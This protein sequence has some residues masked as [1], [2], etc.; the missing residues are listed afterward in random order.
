MLKLLM[1]PAPGERLVRF[2]GDQLSFRLGAPDGRPLPE[3]WQARLR[4]NLGRGQ[5]LRQEIIRAHGRKPHLAQASWR[6]P[7]MRP[8]AAGAWTLSLPLTEAGFFKSKAY[9]IDPSGR[10]Q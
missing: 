3:G 7:P 6:D 4:T 9:A 10:Q 2:V 1:N 8:D 5:V